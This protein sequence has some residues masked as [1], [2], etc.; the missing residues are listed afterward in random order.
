V[1]AGLR[2]L[3]VMKPIVTIIEG[4]F[5]TANPLQ[6]QAASIG[7]D[8]NGSIAAV[9][10]VPERLAVEFPQAKHVRL[11]NGTL[12][13][14]A[15]H[16]AHNHWGFAAFDHAEPLVGVSS[17]G[18]AFER[19]SER[20]DKAPQGWIVGFGW[21]THLLPLTQ[22]D[23]DRVSTTR[24]V[25]VFD[26]S[27]HAVQLNTA[28]EKEIREGFDA[29]V[30]EGHPGTLVEGRMLESSNLVFGAMRLP[31]AALEKS[32]MDLERHY[33]SVGIA[34]LDDL[35]VLTPQIL[36]SLRELYSSQRLTIPCHG[37]ID[38]GRFSKSGIPEPRSV[39]RFRLVGMKSYMDGALGAR[40]AL[41]DQ[42]FIGAGGRGVRLLDRK[43]FRRRFDLAVELGYRHVALH[44]IGDRAVADAA[45]FL[46][47]VAGDAVVD[48]LRIEHFQ[49]ADRVDR[50]RCFEAGIAVCMQ[51]NFI[52]D[53][54][55]YADRLGERA[56]S[57]CEHRS[58]LNS[59]ALLSFG[60]D[61]MPTGPIHGLRCAIEHPNPA[62]RLSVEESLRAYTIDA[63]R[64]SRTDDLR[65]S[66]TVGKE[67]NI[68]VLNRD[69]VKEG[70][71][72][73]DVHVLTTIVSG[74]VR[75]LDPQWQ[76]SFGTT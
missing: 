4:D 32:L 6:P 36:D 51:P 27:T 20:A 62:Q 47:S 53:V 39:G 58:V 54:A 72:G 57:L 26:K 76:S 3:T 30:R 40:S 63:C 69:I 68:A 33:L 60:S 46:C 23:L 41:L 48:R 55:D 38:F 10:A 52:S 45:G 49:L 28:A 29:A 59:G 75:Y 44:A 1:R 19:L 71:I 61:G 74:E 14:P 7:I 5:W 12:G 24:P 2:F 43:S 15:F 65:G 66:L 31:S 8:S 42:P 16:D 73:A 22:S 34:S 50:E 11:P 9:E 70:G 67:A 37:F 56:R 25:A 35:D 13:A 64:C 17:V 18:D 21:N